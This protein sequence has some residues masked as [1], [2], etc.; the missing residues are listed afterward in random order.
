MYKVGEIAKKL[1][2]KISTIHYYD[3]KGLLPFAKRDKQGNRI[4][5]EEDLKAF[6]IIIFLKRSNMPLKK[7]KEFLELSAEG[8]KTLSKR[9]KII[10]EN[11]KVITDK[12]TELTN[13]ID[14]MDYK[15]WYYKTAIEAGSEKV[16]ENYSEKD[17][18]KEIADIFE[19]L[20]NNDCVE[21]FLKK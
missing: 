2:I 16:F 6:Y 10:E 15:L 13:I 4:F 18:P 8:D 7:I 17:I 20:E 5:D 1:D 21:E 14:V 3:K 9:Y 19:R 12:I 11:K